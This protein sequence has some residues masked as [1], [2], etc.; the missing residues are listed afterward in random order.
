MIALG[1]DIGGSGIKA[2]PVSLIDGVLTKKRIRFDTPQPSS[3][4]K[5]MEVVSRLVQE[6]GWRGPVGC[7]F[8]G[9]VRSGVTL[10]AANVDKGWLGFPAQATFE[11]RLGQR[12]VILNDADAAG[13]AELSFGAARG[14]N[15]TVL[16]LTLGTGLG[17]ALFRE[18]VLVPNTEF[19][20]LTMYGDSAERYM[21]DSARK[22][23]KLS[24]SGWAARINE[25]LVITDRL[26]SPDYYILGGGVSNKH[27]KFFSYLKAGAPIVPAKLRNR[28]GI[29]GAAILADAAKTSA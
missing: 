13:L 27:D 11:E 28:A 16:V 9:V 21:T 10:S 17:S 6:F 22:R 2:A 20:H 23:E 1:I 7:T 29:V 19:G 12:V 5:V 15:G 26:L 14:R 4:E 25:Y 8:P 24:W 18:G 3:P